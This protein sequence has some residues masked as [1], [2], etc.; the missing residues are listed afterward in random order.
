MQIRVNG[1]ARQIT[2]ST[3]ISSLLQELRLSNAAVAVELNG[4]ILP[5]EKFAQT[6]L[7]DLDRIEV[8]QFVGGG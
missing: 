3:T 5:K 7:S 8:V 4:E 1:K 2:P 6:L